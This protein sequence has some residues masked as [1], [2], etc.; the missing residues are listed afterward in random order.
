MINVAVLGFGTVGS[1][2]VELID[3]NKNHISAKLE[4]QLNVKYILD[5]RD[6]PDS[7]YK[8]KFVKDFSVIENDPEVKVVA[9]VIGGATFAYDY[10]VRALKAGKS[11]VTSNKELVAQKGYELLELAKKNNVNYFFEASVGGGIP[12]IRP[13]HRCM[14]ANEITKFFGIL[15]GTT[16]YILTKMIEENVAFEDALKNAQALG[17]AE[18][19]PTAD[20]EGID[21]CRKMCILASLAFGTHVYPKDVYAEGITKISLEDVAIADECGYSIKLIGQGE[22]YGEKIKAMVAPALVPHSSLLSGVKDVFNSV[23]LQG[24]AVG[25]VFLCGRGAGKL[26]TASAVVADILDAAKH[27]EFLKGWGWKDETPGRVL[28]QEQLASAWY[29]RV[30]NTVEDVISLYPDADIVYDKNGT[31]AAILKEELNSSHFEKQ[32]K[33]NVLSA[34]RVLSL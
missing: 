22:S 28:S 16:N 14:A 20:V 26:P 1:G 13:M 31:V 19:D 24:N 5:I 18:A 15:N 12:L 17:Y 33:L 32:K 7:P 6:F 3:M 11:V 10:T 30:N 21:A 9:E 8:D 4:D 29:V 25:D 2:V 27:F 23:L 34:I